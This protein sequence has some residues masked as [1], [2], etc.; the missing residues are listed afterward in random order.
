MEMVLIL[1][2]AW[3]LRWKILCSMLYGSEGTILATIAATKLKW[4]VHIGGGYHH[5]NSQYGG[6]LCIYPDI[7]LAIHYAQTRLNVKKA[8]V[9]DLDVHQG[10]GHEMDHLNN[11]DVFIVD[12]YNHNIFP[13]DTEAKKAIGLDMIVAEDTTDED[14]LKNMNK[15]ED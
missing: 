11:P 13:G 5:A 6:G 10:N 7:T 12:V 2:P 3:V 9:V 8:M 15:I 4:A 1:F 14:Y